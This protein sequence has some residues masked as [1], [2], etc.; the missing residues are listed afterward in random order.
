[1][2]SPT[3]PYKRQLYATL[4][5]SILSV[6]DSFSVL[7]SCVYVMVLLIRFISFICPLIFFGR[8]NHNQHQ[9]QRQCWWTKPENKNCNEIYEARLK[10]GLKADVYFLVKWN[11]KCGIIMVYVYK[12]FRIYFFLF[13]NLGVLLYNQKTNTDYR[14]VF[15]CA[16]TV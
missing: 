10:S 6:C 14:C 13:F 2:F 5:K 11:A 3:S 7:S 15:E 9:E 8:L 16:Y 4:N 1:M 12:I